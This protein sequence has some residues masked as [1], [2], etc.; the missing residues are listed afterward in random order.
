MTDNRNRR[1]ALLLAAAWLASLAAGPACAKDGGGDSGG[2]SGGGGDDGDSGGDDGD[3]GGHGGDDGGGRGRGRGRGGDDNDGGRGKGGQRGK[4]DKAA[5]DGGAGLQNALRNVRARISG[6]IIEIEVDR[7][8]G[9][10]I[11][12]IKVLDNRGRL[13]EIYCDA[14]DG[15][16]LKVERD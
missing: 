16:I 10:R 7:Y 14:T 8:R 5:R 4:S 9:R 3:S 6:R 11:Y 12:E 1:T 13:F 2:D 15:R